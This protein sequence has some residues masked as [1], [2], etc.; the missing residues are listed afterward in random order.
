MEP[1]G[2][3]GASGLDVFGDGGGEGEDVVAE[4]ALELVDAGDVES[5]VGAE[6]GGG[7]G[8]HDAG[9]DEGLGGGEFDVEPAV[10]LCLVG[11]EGGHRRAGVAGDHWNSREISR[12]TNVFGRGAPL[13][14]IGAAAS[15]EARH[16][17]DGF[18]S[19]HDI[20]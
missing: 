1:A 19:R 15:P 10:E 4:L 3:V 17:A 2:G 9:L 8:G 5:G 12:N 20:L 18:A 13:M 7:G 6:L 14:M 11:P 16:E